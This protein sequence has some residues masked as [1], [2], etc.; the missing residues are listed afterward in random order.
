M[1]KIILKREKK[2]EETQ[3][4]LIIEQE[5]TNMIQFI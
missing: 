4:V 2:L 3:D 5:Y 1:Y